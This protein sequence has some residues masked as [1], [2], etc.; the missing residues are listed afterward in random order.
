MVSQTDNPG[1]PEDIQPWYGDY[2][3]TAVEGDPQAPRTWRLPKFGRAAVTVV[4]L[5]L[6]S[7]GV[8]AAV[9]LWPDTPSC[10]VG[11]VDRGLTPAE[12]AG[13]CAPAPIVPPITD[14]LQP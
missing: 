5:A 6:A 9:R 2:S 14:A 4:G 11:L 13:M 1:T 3:T 8:V 12:A 10:A 7:G